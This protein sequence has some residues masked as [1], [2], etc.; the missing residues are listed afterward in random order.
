MNLTKKGGVYHATFR[1]ALGTTKSITTRTTNKEDAVKVVNESGIKEL[2][3][4]AK[5]GRLTNEAIGRIIAGKKVT[6]EKSIEPYRQWMESIGRAP[7]TIENN[8]ANLK[9]WMKLMK[10]ANMPPSAVKREHINPWINDPES[11]SKRGTRV[12]KLAAV[13]TFFHYLSASGLCVG[14]PSKLVAINM[15][16]LSH[17]QKET[18]TRVPVT[19]Q[20][21]KTILHT[22]SEAGKSP[23]AFWHFA[24]RISWENGLR[25]GDIASLEWS[26]FQKPGTATIWTEKRDTRVSLPISKALQKLLTEIP[27]THQKYLF[28]SQHHLHN[29]T[30][31]RSTLSVQFSRIASRCGVHKP[32]HSI[33]HAFA[34]RMNNDG[35]SMT[36]IAKAMGHTDTKTT[37]G[38][39]H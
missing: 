24:T 4:A 7:R 28:P 17:R 38:Y 2:E 27:I 8:V 36:D 15:N 22:T 26:C 35:H 19:E 33:R 25:L 1:T 31:K 13:R 37:E 30:K 20:E 12:V 39:V 14:D 16:V 32:F 23:S 6:M 18:K 3:M 9:E 29:D 11:E 34:T 5:S 21:Y 10:I